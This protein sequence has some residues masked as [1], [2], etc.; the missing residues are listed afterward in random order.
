M[1]SVSQ[2]RLDE[3]Q[4]EYGS[5]NKADSEEPDSNK[6]KSVDMDTS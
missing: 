1:Y 5:V 6:D 4:Q 3:E 2:A